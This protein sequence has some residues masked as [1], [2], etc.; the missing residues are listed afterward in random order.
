MAVSELVAVALDVSEEVLVALLVAVALDVSELV[1][2]A[3]DVDVAVLVSA[4]TNNGSGR[5]RM[6]VTK[7]RATGTH[8]R[9]SA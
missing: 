1:A 7:S 4:R 6:M 3:L 9:G 8:N 5:H 2:V